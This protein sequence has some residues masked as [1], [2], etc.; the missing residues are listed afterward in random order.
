MQWK[1][2]NGIR[3]KGETSKRAIW[4]S[5]VTHNKKPPFAQQSGPLPGGLYAIRPPRSRHFPGDQLLDLPLVR[6]GEPA[7]ELVEPLDG[8]LPEVT[9]VSA[10]L[11]SATLP[12]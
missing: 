3:P 11:V 2:Q 4:S 8:A 7:A 1:A 6:R 5:P 12:R 10:L 9:P